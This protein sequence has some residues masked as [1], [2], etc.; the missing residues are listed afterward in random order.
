MSQ[1]IK[2]VSYGLS[3]AL[4]EQAPKPIISKRAPTSGDKGYDL[5]QLWIYT[6]NGAA[7]ILVSIVANVATW[8]LIEAS[9]AAGVFA[10]LTVTPGPISLTGT[11]SINT[12]GSATTT[13]GTGGTGAVAIGNATGNTS[14]TG[15]LSATGNISSVNGNFIDLNTTASANAGFFLFEKNRSGGII[16]S[17][18]SLGAISFAGYDGASYIVGAAIEAVSSGTIGVNRVASDLE[19]YTHPDSVAATPTLRMTIASTGAV[20]IA[21]PTSGVALTVNGDISL[22]AGGMTASGQI[23]A[24]ALAATA[25]VGGFPAELTLS[26][27]SV[28]VAGG[29]GVFV[30][31]PSTGAGNTANAGFIKMYLGS[32]AIYIPYWTQTT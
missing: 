30:I 22:P 19:F 5:G 4:I 25:D 24:S 17:G 8:N 11:T 21:T 13:I 31:N 16:T 2:Q 1:S 12:S 23:T 26:N 7:Y 3:Q 14:V 9:G 10:S 32:S 20:S 18:D 29:T 6:T 28:P 27:A 15:A